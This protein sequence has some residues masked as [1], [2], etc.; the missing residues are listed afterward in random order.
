LLAQH[1]DHDPAA[2]RR[3]L[4]CLESAVARGEATPADLA[5]LT[6]RVLLA[7][8]KRQIYGTQLT[9]HAGRYVAVNLGKP[10]SVNARREAV[11]LEPLAAQIEEMSQR[12][13][14]RPALADCPGCGTRIEIKPP[15][16]RRRTRFQGPDCGAAGTVHVRKGAAL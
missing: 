16:P 4:Q 9:V 1:A 11:G 2:Q 14:P 10:K 8:G 12:R 13:S 3:F 6:D 15:A 5:R 7:G